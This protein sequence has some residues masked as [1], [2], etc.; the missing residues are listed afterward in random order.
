M[1]KA[2]KS[3]L[4]FFVDLKEIGQHSQTLG[5]G[6]VWGIGNLQADHHASIWGQS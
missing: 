5:E 2:M 1:A 6:A 3:S 4:S